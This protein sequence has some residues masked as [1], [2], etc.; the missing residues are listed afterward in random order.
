MPGTD[1]KPA[2]PRRAAREP[3]HA[4]ERTGPAPKKQPQADASKP[5]PQPKA[6]A[7]GQANAVSGL[8]ADDSGQASG[9]ASASVSANAGVER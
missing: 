5:M 3:R 8:S 7:D 1:E 9:Q 6:H 2:K 4:A